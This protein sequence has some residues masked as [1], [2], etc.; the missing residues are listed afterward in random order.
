MKTLTCIALGALLSTWPILSQ[1]AEGEKQPSTSAA[2]AP[3]SQNNQ[4]TRTQVDSVKIT[5]IVP[6]GIHTVAIAKPILFLTQMRPE[7]ITDAAVHDGRIDL[8]FAQQTPGFVQFIVSGHNNWMVYVTPGDSITCRITGT[9]PTSTVHFEGR[10][11]INWQ[12]FALVSGLTANR[13]LPTYSRYNDP[14]VYQNALNAWRTAALDSLT[15]YWQPQKP[16]ATVQ[17]LAKAWIDYEYVRLTYAIL[18]GLP[19]DFPFATYTREADQFLFNSDLLANVSSYQ[20]ASLAKY[21]FRYRRDTAWTISRLAANAQKLLSGKTLDHVLS[22]LTGVYAQKQL[23]ADKPALEKLFVTAQKQVKD[24]VYVAY[25]SKTALDYRVL[26]KPLPDAVLDQTFLTSYTGGQETSL[27][28]LLQQYAGKAVYLDLWASWCVPCRE[29]IS[30]SAEAKTYL[31][32]KSVAYLY[33]SIDK[34]AA[35]WKTAAA[36]DTITNDQFLLNTGKATPFYQ[37]LNHEFIPRYVL[38]DA[39]HK[40]KST[41]APRPNA[42]GTAALKALVASLSAKVVTFN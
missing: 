12:S 32:E 33:I 40:V 6:E 41:Y 25:I 7:Q 22:N 2:L 19:A 9:G 26:G 28:T 11:A 1:A 17:Q 27:R 4:L 42:G 5:C 16:K 24:S 34:N 38:L 18:P 13:L 10:N 31:K 37:F 35:A 23:P 36:Q 29:D 3:D 8:A 21:I 15:Q 30:Q 39:N 14:H 20:N